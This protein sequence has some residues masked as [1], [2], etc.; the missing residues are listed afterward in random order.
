[1][2][3]RV[4]ARVIAADNPLATVD[5]D[6]LMIPWA[7]DDVPGGGAVPHVDTATGGDI[8]RALISKE[9]TGRA[10][11]TFQALVTDRGWAPRRLLLVGVGKRAAL[12]GEVVR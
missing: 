8:T 4:S 3:S 12:S 5:A 9:F 2:P 7:E 10:F 1:M 11:E 6:V